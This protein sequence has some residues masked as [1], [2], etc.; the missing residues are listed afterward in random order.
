MGALT[1]L[2]LVGVT[3][4]NASCAS[5]GPNWSRVT[6]LTPGTARSEVVAGSWEKVATL[7]P[8]SPLVV[9]LKNG[10]RLAGGFKALALEALVLTDPIGQEF[11]IARSTVDSIVLQARD[12]LLDGALIGAGVG[13]G[14]AVATLA[15]AGSGEG[16]VLPSAKWGAPLLLSSI[17][18][19]IGILVDRAHTRQEVIYQGRSSIESESR[20]T[21]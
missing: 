11:R 18:A 3:F 17:G 19:L 16:Y 7:R 9:T 14:T 6:Q 5:V 13:V 10:N 21:R 12:T 2:L 4:F 8:A 1:S 20:S 15:I